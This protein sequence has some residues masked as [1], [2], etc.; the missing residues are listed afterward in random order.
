MQSRD[1]CDTTQEKEGEENVGIL[2]REIQ[3]KKNQIT[4]I[5]DSIGARRRSLR[6]LYL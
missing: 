3:R 6:L 1:Q 5:L 2:K 4:N